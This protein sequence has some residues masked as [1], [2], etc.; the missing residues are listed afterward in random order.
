M[1]YIEQNHILV[2]E[3]SVLP[4]DFVL[5]TTKSLWLRFRYFSRFS[6][7]LILLIRFPLWYNRSEYAL[8][9]A[10]EKYIPSP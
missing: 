4:V 6:F 7:H 2:T 8:S 3:L 5:Q 9:I 10:L 1:D